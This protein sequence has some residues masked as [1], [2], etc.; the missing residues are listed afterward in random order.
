MTSPA[1][2]IANK[3]RSDGFGGIVN[4]AG[5]AISATRE[6]AKPLNVITL[7]D[8]G[9]SPPDTDEQDILLQSVQARVRAK[10]YP[11]GYAAIRSIVTGLTLSRSFSAEAGRYLS[12]KCISGPMNIG[13]AE[14]SDAFLLTANFEVLIQADFGEQIPVGSL[15]WK[16]KLLTWKGK[17]LTW[18]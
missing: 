2:D 15:L 13:R 17:A 4:K 6:P 11:E 3:I 10:E 1:V 16:S 14:A 7:Y 12:I 5:W 9:G 18:T 8:T